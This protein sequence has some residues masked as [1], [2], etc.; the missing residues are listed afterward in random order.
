[1]FCDQEHGATY[2][3]SGED[4]VR[5]EASD[6]GEYWRQDGVEDPVQLCL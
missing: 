3:L 4:L 1:M 2:L 5:E 6:S